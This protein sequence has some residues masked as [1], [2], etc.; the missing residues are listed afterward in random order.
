MESTKNRRSSDSTR[1]MRTRK[2]N[3][4]AFFI[5]VCGSTAQAQQSVQTGVAIIQPR[6]VVLTRTPK[7]A[8]QFPDRKTARVRYPIVSGL[9][10]AAITSRVQKILAV[11]NA[12]GTSLKEYRQ[13]SWLTDFGYNVG[14]NK[15]YLLDITFRQ[16]GMSAYPDSQ[17]KHFLI[18]LKNG[19]VIKAVDAFEPARLAKL[20]ALV[21]E[22]LHREVRE[23][24]QRLSQDKDASAEEKESLRSTFAELKFSEEH[25]DEFSVSDRGITFLFDAGFPHVIQA[26]Q[27]NGEYFFSFA[28][29]QPYIKRDGP[30][31]VFRAGSL[32]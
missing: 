30:L 32:K 26:L 28:Q 31:N 14:Y 13:D 29:L 23:S 4:F 9:A 10:D 12:F 16:E 20:A 15:D 25:L 7:I 21:D 1:N 17:R 6:T 27:P 2:L 22:K 18:N 5:I 24:L 19:E 11:E 3:V 8:R